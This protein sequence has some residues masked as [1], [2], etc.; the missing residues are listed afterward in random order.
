[1]AYVVDEN[2]DVFEELSSGTYREVDERRPKGVVR[3]ATNCEV[4]AFVASRAVA[5]AVVADSLPIAR[6]VLRTVGLDECTISDV[7]IPALAKAWRAYDPDRGSWK[8][9]AQRV[10]KIEA[11]VY[12]KRTELDRKKAREFSLDVWRALDD[13]TALQRDHKDEG[14]L[15]PDVGYI[16]ER[17]SEEDRLVLVLRF[18]GNLSL[19]EIAEVM[20]FVKSGAW[21]RVKRALERAREVIDGTERRRDI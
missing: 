18:W 10:V 14:E 5:W 12:R 19:P 8:A 3:G 20:G 15:S 7:G 17:L 2:G 4:A 16:L 9:F 1:M 11:V 21:L 13:G 6:A